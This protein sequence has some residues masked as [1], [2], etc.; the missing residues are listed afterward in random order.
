MSDLFHGFAEQTQSALSSLTTLLQEHEHAMR[1][2]DR[3]LLEQGSSNNPDSIYRMKVCAEKRAQLEQNKENIQ[4]N[5]S[6]NEIMLLALARISQLET[7]C[8]SLQEQHKFMVSEA[9]K[10]KEQLDDTRMQLEQSQERVVILEA[11]HEE[12]KFLAALSS[13]AEAALTGSL[14]TS[15]AT[16]VSSGTCS[17]KDGEDKSAHMHMDDSTESSVTESGSISELSPITDMSADTRKQIAIISDYNKKG[18]YDIAVNFSKK[19]LQDLQA[20]TPQSK[21][22]RAVVLNTLALLYRDI[23]DP[24]QSIPLLE[25]ALRIREELH[26]NNHIRVASIANNLAIFYSKT[27]QY[28]LAENSCKKALTVK[29]L[30]LGSDSVEVARQVSNLALICQSRHKLEEAEFNFV[31]ALNIYQTELGTKDKSVLKTM[32]ELGQFYLQQKKYEEAEK[33]LKQVV[34]SGE[35]VKEQGG[36]ALWTGVQPIILQC[37]KSLKDLYSATR[38][39]ELIKQTELRFQKLSRDLKNKHSRIPSRNRTPP[40]SMLP[41]LSSQAPAR[42]SPTPTTPTLSV[43]GIPRSESRGSSMSRPSR[44]KQL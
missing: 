37:V 40:P 9:E 32:T 14:E 23:G 4:D 38:N 34:A 28:E 13:R 16:Q 22:D 30:A 2:L 26:G 12:V 1:D 24:I 3:E 17:K 27:R 20:N 33:F 21:S 44:D 18:S 5:I 31:R 10:L 25:E 6:Q 15:G 11:E 19:T 43:T 39:T 42:C 41:K 7:N 29:E 36:D 8:F 35:E